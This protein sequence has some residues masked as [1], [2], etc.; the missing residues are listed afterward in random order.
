MTK[1]KHSHELILKDTSGN[2]LKLSSGADIIGVDHTFTMAPPSSPTLLATFTRGRTS[3]TQIAQLHS[4]QLVINASTLSPSAVTELKTMYPS[5]YDSGTDTFKLPIPAPVPPQPS[6]ITVMQKD[7]VFEVEVTTGGGVAFKCTIDPLGVI[8][9][10]AE[11]PPATGR[12]KYDERAKVD[13][14][15]SLATIADAQEKIVDCALTPTLLRQMMDTSITNPVV[16]QVHSLSDVPE[17]F[18]DLFFDMAKTGAITPDDKGAYHFPPLSAT[19]PHDLEFP[20]PFHFIALPTP[21]STPANPEFYYLCKSTTTG[22]KFVYSESEG[23]FKRFTRFDFVKDTS[24]KCYVELQSTV[25]GT[26]VLRHLEI[27]ST[28]DLDGSFIE[29]IQDFSGGSRASLVSALSGVTPT[30][31]KRKDSTTFDLKFAPRS[32][33]VIQQVSPDIKETKI[34]IDD[35]LMSPPPP[36]PPPPPSLTVPSPRKNIY[37]EKPK[38][39][40][41]K[42]PKKLNEDAIRYGGTA[43]GVF[44]MAMLLIPGIGPILFALGIALTAG[45]QIF[46][47]NLYKFNDNPYNHAKTEYLNNLTKLQNQAEDEASQ[48]WQHETELGT[49]RDMQAYFQ[50]LVSHPDF[51]SAD[52]GVLFERLTSLGMFDPADYTAFWSPDNLYQR[53]CFHEELTTLI[54]GGVP[55][56]PAQEA[57]LRKYGI[58]KP[59]ATAAEIAEAKKIFT[60]D[61]TYMDGG[62]PHTISGI[63]AI[64]RG[65][66]TLDTINKN[67]QVVNDQHRIVGDM[68][69][70]SSGLGIITMLAQFKGDQTKIDAFIK[71]HAYDF[72]R[73]FMYRSDI[74]QEQMEDFLGKISKGAAADI[75]TA[76]ADIESKV[77][78]VESKAA[79]QKIWDT[80]YQKTITAMQAIDA[81]MNADAAD[82]S[83]YK[84]YAQIEESAQMMAWAIYREDALRTSKAVGSVGTTS[85]LDSVFGGTPLDLTSSTPMSDYQNTLKIKK[86]L[87]NNPDFAKAIAEEIEASGQTAPIVNGTSYAGVGQDSLQTIYTAIQTATPPSK[88]YD[89]QVAL[90]ISNVTKLVDKATVRSDLCTDLDNAD[91]KTIIDSAA[92][93]L[94]GKIIASST[95]PAPTD[96]KFATYDAVMQK[97][98]RTPSFSKLDAATQQK[99]VMLAVEGKDAI[100]A[101]SKP[102]ADKKNAVKE[103]DTLVDQLVSGEFVEKAL[104]DKEKETFEDDT[105]SP[106]VIGGV[107][108]S[109]ADITSRDA[110]RD[111]LLSMDAMLEKY[112]VPQSDRKGVIDKLTTTPISKQAI[113]KA[114]YDLYD[115]QLLSDC[116][117]KAATT[118]KTLNTIFAEIATPP[119]DITDPTKRTA[120]IARL[121]QLRALREGRT[122]TELEPLKQILG[123]AEVDYIMSHG[124]ETATPATAQPKTKQEKKVDEEM[125][126]TSDFLDQANKILDEIDNV[127]SII[128]TTVSP[129][130]FDMQVDALEAELVTLLG[131]KGVKKLYGRGKNKIATLKTVKGK[132]AVADA[133]AVDDFIKIKKR[134]A[135]AL[136]KKD[137]AQ[138]KKLAKKKERAAKKGIKGKAKGA[139]KQKRANNAKRFEQADEAVNDTSGTR[140]EF[141][142]GESKEKVKDFESAKEYKHEAE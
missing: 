41:T 64:A 120:L 27:P 36:P 101:T 121:V 114:I 109:H 87:L 94:K 59:T 127:D 50:A 113:A 15:S 28:P 51:L 133:T 71:E 67:D 122:E 142:P 25:T 70:Q 61:F 14:F 40:Q 80:D 13:D 123:D 108:K 53:Q 98:L 89:V 24:G 72:A 19:P 128:G 141:E 32:V 58:I 130:V 5:T 45:S 76:M 93:A 56:E 134:I 21:A 34:T 126:K 95:Y 132:F 106:P 29:T 84:T 43:I 16:K 81:T 23:G 116:S 60:E 7:G 68:I 4:D 92:T 57:F 30:T 105:V 3:P 115:T 20:A 119:L 69:E 118:D 138:A 104:S 75:Q 112:G 9:D 26:K 8:L 47:N 63:E 38:K 107:T 79:Q 125:I 65:L 91:R 22:Q 62:T 17:Q 131:K 99:I 66:A 31:C 140:H 129:A 135:E 1:S 90:G 137:A 117:E 139:S 44:M 73:R 77:P 2:R 6:P 85:S 136:K 100:M 78:L 96:A 82:S 10:I 12:K 102:A 55:P 74:P 124:T 52:T 11:P 97:F 42:V 35:I 33:S 111:D 83:K 110:A 39:V 54:S 86:L 103:L 88:L 49:A 18:I 46:A 48:F 37:V